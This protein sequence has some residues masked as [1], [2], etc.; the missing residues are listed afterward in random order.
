M[1]MN[2]KFNFKYVRFDLIAEYIICSINSNTIKNDGEKSNSF[3]R[4]DP[5]KQIL[6]NANKKLS[7]NELHIMPS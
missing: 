7:F 6:F 3:G 2:F 1:R 4:F 5:I